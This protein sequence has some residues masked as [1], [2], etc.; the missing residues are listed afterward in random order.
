[1]DRVIPPLTREEIRHNLKIV[2]EFYN[3]MLR[4]PMLPEALKLGYKLRQHR[5]TSQHYIEYLELL[6]ENYYVSS[7]NDNTKSPKYSYRA[8]N[9]KTDREFTGTSKEV[10]QEIGSKKRSVE[11][12]SELGLPVNGYMI[13][14]RDLNSFIEMKRRQEHEQEQES[15]QEAK[16]TSSQ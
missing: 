5:N 9:I 11:Y 2:E 16:Q 12:A 14:R 10:A 8:Y 7:K 6:N 15:K 13:E 4:P 1:M 3:Y